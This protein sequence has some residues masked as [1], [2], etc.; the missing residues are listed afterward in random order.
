MPPDQMQIINEYA[1]VDKDTG[2]LMFRCEGEPWHKI[3]DHNMY[4][5]KEPGKNDGRL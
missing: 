1:A 2:Q 4:Q 5:Y 3:A